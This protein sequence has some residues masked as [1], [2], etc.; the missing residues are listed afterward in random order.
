MPSIAICRLVF[1]RRVP[2]PF[3]LVPSH[4]WRHPVMKRV[5]LTSEQLKI[6]LSTDAKDQDDFVEDTALNSE[7]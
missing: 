6:M 2:R 3:P 1:V 5:N 7:L 4:I